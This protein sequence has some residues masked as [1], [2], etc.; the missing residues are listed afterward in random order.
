MYYSLSNIIQNKLTTH[1]KKP[2]HENIIQINNELRIQNNP[3]M[4]THNIY[5]K[6]DPTH[7][8]I[9]DSIHNP[10]KIQILHNHNGFV[11][12]EMTTPKELHF[13]RTKTQNHINN[14]TNLANFRTLKQKKLKNNP[15]SQQLITTT[16]LTNHNIKNT[17]NLN[18]LNES[19]QKLI[20]ELLQNQKRPN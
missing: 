20:L 18:I 7:N 10:T 11:L 5:H 19:L 6:L 13:E 14:P 9:M 12:L 2:T 15:T 16:Q 4:L 17:K 1:N 8:T 3:N